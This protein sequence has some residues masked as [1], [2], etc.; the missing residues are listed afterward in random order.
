MKRQAWI[1]NARF[2]S[3]FILAPPFLALL[4]VLLLP[5]SWRGS[6]ELGLAGWVLLV[7]LI[8]VSH[9]YSTL[10]RTYFNPARF[11][12]HRL[13]YLGIPLLCYIAGVLLYQ[14]GDWL[15]W[16]VLA[17]AAVFHFIRQQY[18]FMRLYSRSEGA[19][20]LAGIIDT[21]TIYAATLYPILFWHLR[22]G[23]RFSWFVD[24]DF[25]QWN[26]PQ[27]LDA[28]G[29]VYIAV[30]IAYLLKEII[31]IQRNG[32]LNIPRNALILGTALS[33]YVGIVALNADLVFTML[34]VI[35]HGIPY[36]ALIWYKSRLEAPGAGFINRK[37]LT[38][39]GVLVFIGIIAGIAWLEEGL[40]DGMIWG[41][42]H[43]AVFG[44]FQHLPSIRDFNILAFLVPLLA[45]P[46]A[47][48]YVLDG[49]IWRR[50]H[51]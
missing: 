7:L 39:Y 14:A 35:S 50:G 33:W 38:R 5:A 44:M 16:R 37:L 26:S 42:E 11:A 18:G 6:G 46:Q 30:L 1:A 24:G 32:S 9:V 41:G 45:L 22:P 29:I 23:R 34:N 17:Y 4:A 2:D 13:M 28:A 51:E 49:F 47:T 25:F 19:P 48:H 3:A 8:D 27:L 40:W 36:M 10:F 15:F 21:L 20:R 31:L 12:R 43:A